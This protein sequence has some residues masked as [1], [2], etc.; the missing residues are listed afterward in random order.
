ML[1][2]ESKILKIASADAKLVDLYH[3][4]D[5]ILI[6][7]MPSIIDLHAIESFLGEMARLFRQGGKS[8]RTGVIAN[9]VRLKTKSF[10]AIEALIDAS[11]LPL[12][13]SLRDTQN[14]SIAMESGLGICELNPGVSSKDREH[15]QPILDWLHQEIPHQVAEPVKPASPWVPPR[16]RS[17]YS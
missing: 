9:R 4:A 6:P 10:H 15:W 2:G 14:Y 8:K 7:I 17:A 3:R 1:P 5:T 13:G 12:V 16:L 11:G